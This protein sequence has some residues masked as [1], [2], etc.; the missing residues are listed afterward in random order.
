MKV[1]TAVFIALCRNQR[2]EENVHKKLEEI[3]KAKKKADKRKAKLLRELEVK[4]RKLKRAEDKLEKEEERREKV[5]LRVAKRSIREDSFFKKINV[6][7]I[8][9][10]ISILCVGPWRSR[11]ADAG[12]GDAPRRCRAGPPAA[13]STPESCCRLERCRWAAVFKKNYENILLKL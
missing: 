4:E 6:K 11:L 9:K 5:L 7:H 10:I 13:A 1:E 3:E 2:G 12:R 8:F